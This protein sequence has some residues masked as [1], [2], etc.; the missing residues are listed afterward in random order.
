MRRSL[1]P[2]E[3]RQFVERDMYSAIM[4]RRRSTIRRLRE[5]KWGQ[6]D[7]GKDEIKAGRFSFKK[8][9]VCLR[10][11]IVWLTFAGDNLSDCREIAQ[12]PGPV[13]RFTDIIEIAT[14]LQISN[15][16][17]MAL[18]LPLSLKLNTCVTIST[19]FQNVNRGCLLN[20][21]KDVYLLN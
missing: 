11:R 13:R 15:I 7:G 17:N 3:R 12:M 6:G 19:R 9:Q 1:R 4:S 8:I 20:Y 2:S 10:I 16:S 21:M 5:T 18:A 14:L